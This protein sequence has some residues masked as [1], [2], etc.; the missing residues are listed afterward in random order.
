MG[1]LIYAVRGSTGFSLKRGVRTPEDVVNERLDPKER[2]CKCFTFSTNG[3]YF[4]YC[5]SKRTV[6]AETSTGREC[7][8]VENGK[9]QC[10]FFSPKD[11]YLITYEPYVIYGTRMNPDGTE[12]KPNPNLRFW[13]VPSG[14]LLA[15]VIA[16]KQA[17]WKP[18][19]TEDDSIALRT[20]GSEVLFY[21]NGNFE[22]SSNKVVVKDIALL[23]VSPGT[24]PYV[25]CFIPAKNQPAMIQLRTLND[26]LN[27]MFTKTSFNCDRCVMN[28]NS[29]GN[30]L[31]VTASVDVDKSNQSYYGVSHIYCLS[32]K[33]YGD[34]FQVPLQKEGPVHCVEWS[35]NGKEFCV[36]YGFMPSRV[37]IFNLRGDTVWDIGEGHRNEVHYNPQSTILTTCGFG[38]IASGKMEFWNLATRK[39]ISQFCVP[40][41]THFEWAPDGQHLCTSTTAPRLRTDNCYRIWKYQGELVYEYFYKNEELWNV[42]WRPSDA[43][44]KFTIEEPTAQQRSTNSN[45]VA[46][47]RASPIGQLPKG[48]ITSQGRY[49]P[50]HLRPKNN[51][52][53]SNN[54]ADGTQWNAAAAS[55]PEESDTEKRI[56]TLK[57][58]LEEIEKLKQREKTGQKLELNQMEKVRNAEKLQAEL[59]KLVESTIGN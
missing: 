4:A 55:R 40:H 58:K 57:K 11:H 2:I 54:K 23:S 53:A 59:Q 30:A 29:K 38:N 48:A 17:V 50:P 33:G 34:C 35:P 22:K 52:N 43:Y 9:T 27:V 18:H 39:E 47:N 13:E 7:F 44:C 3:T 25:A 26:S 10:I 24:T 5:D 15:T 16:D 1:D 20:H 14:K 28:W 42:K 37:T 6:L 46:N 51:Q 32:A 31:L 36:C 56:R 12:K 19:F 8:S 41:T 45:Q 49:V 21:K